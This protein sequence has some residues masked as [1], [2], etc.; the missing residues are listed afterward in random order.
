MGG[1]LVSD[2]GFVRVQP[3]RR[4]GG[5]DARFFST[6]AI[7]RIPT[8]QRA[9]L[10]ATWLWNGAEIVRLRLGSHGDYAVRLR[11]ATHVQ[12]SARALYAAV[13]VKLRG[14]FPI[15]RIDGGDIDIDISPAM[16]EARDDLDG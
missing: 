1:A 12:I 7:I 10:R 9:G 3:R 8:E 6:L 5:D 2:D 11:S 14:R 16:Q 15:V 4:T 13:G